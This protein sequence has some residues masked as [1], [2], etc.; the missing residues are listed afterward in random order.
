[1]SVEAGAALGHGPRPRGAPGL[2]SP[3]THRRAASRKAQLRWARSV[4]M[5]RQKKEAAT[6]YEEHREVPDAGGHRDKGRAGTPQ[7]EG[8]G[9]DGKAQTAR[10]SGHDSGD[11][12]AHA[13]GAQHNNGDMEL[14]DLKRHSTG[15][16]QQMQSQLTVLREKF[17]KQFGGRA[18][19]DEFDIMVESA[20]SLPR[21]LGL[22]PNSAEMLSTPEEREE[23]RQKEFDRSN[24]S[25]TGYIALDEWHN[26]AYKH[27]AEKAA[28]LDTNKS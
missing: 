10:G 14:T 5:Q 7:D 19:D 6:E 22:A 17:T 21:R 4:I 28:S 24:A 3:R 13:A 11:G 16:S 2:G 26:C 25:G 18:T 9:H 1:M 27:L 12:D 20:G 8:Q 23:F 15:I